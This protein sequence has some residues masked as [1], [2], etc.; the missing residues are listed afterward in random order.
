M[1]K[2][3]YVLKRKKIKTAPVI[4]IVYNRPNHTKR[5]IE[6]LKKNK[7]AN[8]TELFIFSDAPKDEKDIEGVFAVREYINSLKDGFKKIS[9]I[10]YKEN[11]GVLNATN[12]ACKEIS[13]KYESFIGLEDD[14][15]TNTDFLLFMNKALYFYRYNNKVMLITAFTHENVMKRINCLKN[16][17]EDVIFSYAFHSWGWGS[18]SNRWEDIDITDIDSKWYRR[19]LKHILKGSILSWF[20]LLAIGRASKN[21]DKTSLWDIRLSFLMYKNDKVCVWPLKHSYTSNIGFDGSGIHKYYFNKR[22]LIFTK[23]EDDKDIV[24]THDIKMSKSI[25]LCIGIMIGLEVWFKNI[26]ATFFKNIFI[27]RS[28]GETYE[29]N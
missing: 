5:T 27:V 29:K 9:I 19:N 4:L 16:K 2:E 28:K 26:L 18:W 20:H 14:I 25:S 6:A 15:E 17:K 23:K 21:K 11:Q 13:K 22:D 1:E 8:E 7:L 12:K 24:F 3:K 10:E